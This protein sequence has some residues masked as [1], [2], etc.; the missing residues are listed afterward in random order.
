VPGVGLFRRGE[1][2]KDWRTRVETSTGLA[3]LLGAT[4]A[5]ILSYTGAIDVKTALAAVLSLMVAFVGYQMLH[6]STVSSGLSE[7]QGQRL[8]RL[9]T[10]L[11]QR[12]WYEELVGELAR[13]ERVVLL[14]SH[15]PRLASTSGLAAKRTAWEQIM[16]LSRTTDI[17]FKLLIAVDDPDKLQWAKKVVEELAQ[18]D[19]VSVAVVALDELNVSPLSVQIVDDSCV[20]IID[21]RRGYHSLSDNDRDLVCRHPEVVQFFHE[22]YQAYWEK[23]V[24]VKEGRRLYLDRLNAFQS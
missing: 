10:I 3:A 23:A 2:V 11:P 18:K 21:P 24:L 7:L 15:E 4:V 6:N 12:Q 17:I 1:E 14:T 22:Y 19:N 8:Q 9:G 20:F 5:A 16:T 13:A